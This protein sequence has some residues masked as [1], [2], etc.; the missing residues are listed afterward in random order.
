M[1]PN[2]QRDTDDLPVFFAFLGYARVKAACKMFVKFITGGIWH[3]ACT[4]LSRRRRW[5]A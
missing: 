5:H 2:V 3:A 1:V 4:G